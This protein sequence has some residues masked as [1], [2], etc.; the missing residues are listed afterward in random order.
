[1]GIDATA[2]CWGS[3]DFRLT[4]GTVRDFQGTATTATLLPGKD[5]EAPVREESFL[6]LFRQA[7]AARNGTGAVSVWMPSWDPHN[8]IEIQR[9][10]GANATEVPFRCIE[11]IGAPG[12]PNEFIVRDVQNITF[13]VSG[14]TAN[15]TPVAGVVN[16][17][18]VVTLVIGN[19][20]TSNVEESLALSSWDSANQRPIITRG[21]DNGGAGDTDTVTVAVV[22]FTGANWT[23]SEVT[24][25]PSANFT[26]ENAA[27]SV[28]DPGKTFVF[29]EVAANGVPASVLSAH[30]VQHVVEV[31]STTNVAVGVL[32]SDQAAT[33]S[34]RVILV[35][36]SDASA[37][38]EWVTGSY[39]SDTSPTITASS[40]TTPYECSLAHWACVNTG[41][42]DSS[43]DG[44]Y[45][46][47]YEFEVV[48]A[49]EWTWTLDVSTASNIDY[50]VQV[51]RWPGAGVTTDFRV[52][53][54]WAYFQAGN[55]TA[56]LVA[57]LDYDPPASAS[58]AFARVVMTGWSGPFN[59]RADNANIISGQSGPGLRNARLSY[60]TD[61]TAGFTLTTDD[62]HSARWRFM[63]EIIE[64]V[65]EPGG[66]NEMIVRDVGSI[67]LVTTTTADSASVGTVVTDAD[68]M[69]IATGWDTTSTGYFNGG[70]RFFATLEWVGGG[71]DVVRATRLTTA[72]EVEVSYALVEWT[73]ANWL[74][75]HDEQAGAGIGTEVYAHGQTTIRDQ[76]AIFDAT[77]RPNNGA[78]N[79]EEEYSF[80]PWISSTTEWSA[81]RGEDPEASGMIVRAA[82]LENTDSADPMQVE[83]GAAVQT[84]GGST[85]F[86]TS[87]SSNDLTSIFLPGYTTFRIYGTV[88]Q[89]S[90][91]T[92]VNN[93]NVLIGTP[94]AGANVVANHESVILDTQHNLTVIRLPGPIVDNS[95]VGGGGGSGKGGVNKGPGR[96]GGRGGGNKK[97]RSPRFGATLIDTAPEVY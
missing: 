8:G 7:W 64:Y 60:G 41:A 12:G 29:T 94:G 55:S 65:G 73:G 38:T 44:G 91:S 95:A 63:W 70:G 66:G 58:S 42:E 15:G 79:A 61:I 3:T 28:A 96:G 39:V 69:V 14:T 24:V 4:H 9:A 43:L 20:V 36:S 77:F 49:S 47:G 46:A 81:W 86:N 59:Q 72:N 57:G 56:D 54:G 16:D 40:V 75:F 22:E 27:I 90:P 25:T 84:V 32:N 21:S 23:V 76:T 11:Y 18:K 85:V 78:I 31:T 82:M 92:G 33:I 1:M 68:A 34:V 71:T 13:G 6:M 88:T 97:N 50:A 93:A 53:R 83:R 87:L 52:Q 45:V 10:S 51:Q 17:A 67:P 37:A 89:N 30:D 80:R 26:T 19:G 35:E 5:Y 74:C 48:S 2:V 62:T